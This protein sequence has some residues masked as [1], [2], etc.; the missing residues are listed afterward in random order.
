[1]NNNDRRDYR[2]TNCGRL[3][4]RAYL[5]EGTH[6]ETRCPKCGQMLTVEVSNKLAT[7]TAQQVQVVSLDTGKN[8]V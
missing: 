2:C 7:V 1:M 3:Q 5:A 4:F 6:L 8:V